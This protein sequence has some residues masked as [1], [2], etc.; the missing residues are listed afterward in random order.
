MNGNASVVWGLG[1]PKVTSNV[2]IRQSAYDFLFDL[3]KNCASIF[4]CFNLPH[5][6]L[7]FP[8]G[9]TPFEFRGNVWH[10]KTR[11]PRLLCGIA[12]VILFCCFDTIQACNGQMDR[13][14]DE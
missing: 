13:W 3:N 2:T 14:M 12:C 9:V 11:D 6:H 10:Q 7:V 4:Y 5:L 8:L 1:A